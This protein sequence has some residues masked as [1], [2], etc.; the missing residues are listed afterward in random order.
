MKQFTFIEKHKCLAGKIHIAGAAS[1]NTRFRKAYVFSAFF[2]SI[3]LF[4]VSCSPSPM[5]TTIINK[6]ELQE[7]KNK[8]ISIVSFSAAPELYT[9]GGSPG[10]AYKGD[11][12]V[13]LIEKLILRQFQGMRD[14]L[15]QNLQ[16]VG[17]S[18]YEHVRN[19]IRVDQTE[20]IAKAIKDAKAEFGIVVYSQFGWEWAH[21]KT[22]VTNYRFR[23][24][25]T[26]HNNQG[27]VIWEAA[28]S[29][30]I[31]P[32]IGESFKEQLSRMP[33]LDEFVSGVIGEAPSIETILSYY[34]RAFVNYPR[35][36]LMLIEDDLIGKVHES[37]YE[38]IEKAGF[39]IDNIPKG[40]WP[41]D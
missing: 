40:E 23:T 5:N 2:L 32:L 15:S 7:I 21:A 30:I 33:S 3:V 1:T 10:L 24:A 14:A 39:F 8:P 11:Q 22:D 37:V 38:R 17:S 35:Y 18:T 13:K 4:L 36:L 26:I 27:K 19:R 20:Q 28:F 29:F 9:L 12:G 16:I 34:E 41:S 25:I 6:T 31:Y